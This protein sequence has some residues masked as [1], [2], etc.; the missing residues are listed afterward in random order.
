MYTASINNSFNFG[1]LGNGKN[2]PGV[3]NAKKAV[4][5]AKTVANKALSLKTQANAD[6]FVKASVGQNEVAS[7]EPKKTSDNK[8][9]KSFMKRLVDNYQKYVRENSDIEES[10]R[11]NPGLAAADLLRVTVITI[12]GK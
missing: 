3:S 8:E 7:K 11:D 5:A 6:T 9:K 10:Y 1:N 2:I 4:N 12:M